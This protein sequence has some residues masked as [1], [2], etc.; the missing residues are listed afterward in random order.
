MK[1]RLAPSAGFLLLVAWLALGAGGR[2]V[3]EEEP[4]PAAPASEYVVVEYAG[5]R[6]IAQ[7]DD[8]HIPPLDQRGFAK[9]PVPPGTTAE[10]YARALAR[11]PGI[12]SALPDALVYAAR[13]PNDPLY[14]ANQAA[15]LNIIGAPQAWDLSVGRSE[16]VVAV[17]DTGADLTHPDLAPRL[18]RNP[19]EVSGDGIDNDG[20]GCIDDVHGCRFIDVTPGNSLACG[21]TSSARTGNVAD[22]NGTLTSSAHSHGTIVAGILGA[23]GDNGIGVTGMA[24]NIRI[25]VVKVLDCG[26]TS[27]TPSGSMFNVAQGID[28]AVRMGARVINLSLSSA[29]GDT[30]ADIPALRAAIELAQQRGVIIVAAAGNWGSLPNPSPGYP[31]A[32]TQYP[33]VV[34]VGAMDTSTGGWANYSA[35]GAA[36]DIAAPGDSLASTVRTDLGG[37]QPYRVVGRGTSFAAPLVSG[38]FAL[39]IARNSRLSVGE[40]LDLVRT[41]ASVAP[42]APHGGNWAG[43]GIVHAGRAVA[44]VPALVTGNAFRDWKD[45]GPGVEV[46]ARVDGVE[47]GI[48]STYAFGPASPY[49][50]RISSEAE[51]LGCGAPGRTI[52]FLIQGQPATPTLPW[53]GP[54]DDLGLV[55]RDIS[56]VTPDPGPV[57]R[58]RVGGSWSNIAHLTDDGP[59]L[60]TLSYLPEGWAAAYVWDPT[61]P[62]VVG[63]AG[64]FRRVFPGLPAYTSSWET[65]KRYDAFWVE[66][67]PPTDIE[68]PNPNPPPRREVQL[69]PG[70]NNVVYTGTSRRVADALQSIAGR[71]TQVLYWDNVSGV[72]MTYVPGR[73]RFLNDFE[74]LLKLKVYWIYVTEPVTLVME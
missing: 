17:L 64:G 18:W 68:V 9:L 20:N 47:C 51:R 5:A 4:T 58:Q 21:Y 23:A 56:I 48:G 19:V 25:M 61:I 14:A 34:A 28:Y 11:R 3:A 39:V 65:V 35:W 13:V 31:A 72:W 62:S 73:S 43:A 71:Y 12:R 22:D 66:A 32:Y 1:E 41:T 57:V 69:S 40:Y 49:I 55:G 2:P 30:T 74:A 53:P 6:A 63:G 59:P 37:A 38:S 27:G 29:P 10:E 70:W 7:A 46:R 67:S 24:W 60:E 50:I 42:P 16:V 45:I 52:T 44:R 36:I 8:D 33:N 15:T 26:G 54:N